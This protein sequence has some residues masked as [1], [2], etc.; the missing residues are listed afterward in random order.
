M[1]SSNNVLVLFDMSNFIHRSYHSLS[2]E[3]FKR[4]DGKA[5]NALYGT[6]NLIMNVINIMKKS[7]KNVYPVAC[8][9]T[10]KSKLARVNI[11]E[12]YKSQRPSAPHDLKH[13]FA[14]VHE[15]IN[16]FDISSITCESYEADDIIAS[17]S[18]QNKN[19]YDNIVIV[20]TDKDFNQCL[21]SENI[22]IY[23][24]SKK[25]YVYAS[26]VHEKYGVI[27]Q[28]FILY[29]ALVGDKIDNIPGVKGIGPKIA[30]ELITQANGD[31]NILYENAKNEI[32]PKNKSKLIIDNYEVLCTSLQLATLRT[33]LEIDQNFKKFDQKSLKTNIHAKDFLQSMN[34]S[35]FIRKYC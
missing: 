14:W 12:N 27:P 31:I 29:Q 13:Q 18:H 22:S 16:V 15:L 34:F 1:A 35:S 26:N 9:D 30:P 10:A 5:T 32:L 17:I 3:K 19:K 25:D 2:P 20:S 8:F 23:N 7:Y 24:I 21:T 11:D 4:E 6:V 28:H 33:D